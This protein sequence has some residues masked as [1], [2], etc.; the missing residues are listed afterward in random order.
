MRRVVLLSA[1]FVRANLNLLA[2]FEKVEKIESLSNT[3]Y[4]DAKLHWREWCL[5]T[6]FY[7]FEWDNGELRFADGRHRTEAALAEGAKFIPFWFIDHYWT[8]HVPHPRTRT[9]RMGD[10]EELMFPQQ[11]A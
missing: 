8:E 4:G 7:D 9:L 5:P 11:N 1:D 10:F 3:R 6:I 2:Q